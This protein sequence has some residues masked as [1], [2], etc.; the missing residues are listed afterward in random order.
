MDNY[1]LA[2]RP[3]P[4]RTLSADEETAWGAWFGQLGEAIVD[5]GH[6]VGRVR[7]MTSDGPHDGES[8]LGGYI[9][10]SARDLDAAT[11]LAAGCPG[12]KS[13]VA[14]DIGEIVDM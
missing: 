3:E 6:R 1:V 4:G 2:F 14:V 12:L 10:V 7:T 5:R 9:V 8:R 11:D 13:G